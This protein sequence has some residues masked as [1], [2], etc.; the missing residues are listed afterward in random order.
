MAAP[1]VNTVDLFSYFDTLSVKHLQRMKIFLEQ[2]IKDKTPD[3]CMAISELDIH[4][5]ISY[6]DG[7]VTYDECTS[8]SGSK[9]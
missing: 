1:T 5:F 3:D 8:M 4:D 2:L 9:H 6:R 7:F